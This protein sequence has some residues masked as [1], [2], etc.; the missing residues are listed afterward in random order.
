[1]SLAPMSL[2]P[3][4]LAPMSLECQTKHHNLSQ[5][6]CLWAHLPQD[7]NWEPNSFKKIINLTTVEETLAIIETLPEVLVKN[8]MFFVMK[9]GIQPIWEDPQNRKGGCFSY[10]IINKHILQVWKELVFVLVGNTLSP[11]KNFMNTVTGISLSP[12][13]QF[14]V[15]K[16]WMSNCNHQNPQM[17]TTTI[18]NFTPEGC[19]FKN[20]VPEF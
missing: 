5:V 20:H 11:D 8:C 1:M 12:K 15:V 19:L 2:A 4:S 14:C 9:D 6:W 7:D 17:V 13:K 18:E 3:M 16:I 10:R